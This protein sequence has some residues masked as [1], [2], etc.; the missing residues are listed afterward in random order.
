M[1]LFLHWILRFLIQSSRIW[2]TRPQTEFLPL[3][4]SIVSGGHDQTFRQ[5]QEQG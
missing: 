5:E 1:S 2:L 3:N 4:M